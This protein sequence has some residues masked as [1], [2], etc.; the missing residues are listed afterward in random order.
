LMQR[1]AARGEIPASA[2]IATLSRIVPIAAA[3]RA[4]VLRKDFEADFLTTMIDRVLLP[5]FG[6]KP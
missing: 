4:L 1:A 5:A 2:D 3:Y 6:L